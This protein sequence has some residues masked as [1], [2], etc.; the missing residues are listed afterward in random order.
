MRA[1]LAILLLGAAPAPESV[2]V[3]GGWGA[4]H[5]AS[6]RRCYAIAR[7][8]G[9]GAGNAFASVADWP[10]RHIRRQLSI[11]LSREASPGTRVTLSMG[12]RRFDLVSGGDSAWAADA[13]TDRAI[14][15]AMR[16]ARSMSVESVARGGG[17]FADTYILTGSATA[18]DA[19][20]LACRE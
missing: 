4:F 6:L 17:A 11:R 13:A 8:V 3:W 19:A 1:L 2:G 18:I 16:S 14:V 7:P 10:D 20:T 15:A 9:G 5:D 12:E